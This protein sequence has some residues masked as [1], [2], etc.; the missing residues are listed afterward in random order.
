MDFIYFLCKM[1]CCV[2][3]NL[4]T[5]KTD[6]YISLVCPIFRVL[7]RCTKCIKDQQIH[8]Y[9]INV[10]LL[11]YGHQHVSASHVA[12]FKVISLKTRIQL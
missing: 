8:C 6:Q 3:I 7:N 11:Y 2:Y 12:I 1:L 5:S 4:A 10:L 9:F